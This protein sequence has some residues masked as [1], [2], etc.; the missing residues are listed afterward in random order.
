MRSRS[1]A[2]AAL[3]K[4]TTRICGTASPRSSSSRRY[5]PQRVQVLPVPAEASIR[6]VPCQRAGEDVEG[7]RRRVRHGAALLQCSST[8]RRRAAARCVE[9]GVAADR[10]RRATPVVGGVVAFGERPASLDCQALRAARAAACARSCPRGLGKK[11]SGSHRPRRYSATSCS[12]CAAASSTA[13][14]ANGA[15]VERQPVRAPAATPRRRRRTAPDGCSQAASGRR[16]APGRSASAPGRAGRRSAK[17]ACSARSRRRSPV[18]SV[19][20][21]AAAAARPWPRALRRRSRCSARS[22]RSQLHCAERAVGQLGAGAG[23]RT[24]AR[25]ASAPGSSSRQQ[26]LRP[27]AAR[28][29]PSGRKGSSSCS[30]SAR[31][32]QARC[33]GGGAA[34]RG[35]GCGR[36]RHQLRPATTWRHSALGR[37]QRAR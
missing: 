24:A 36:T 18:R 29:R 3:V 23:Q 10:P 27:G 15:V 4:V 35:R 9:V 13:R 26:P 5:R 17:P 22:S 1:S 8:G 33:P 25:R 30:S 14:G 34:G 20:G 11:C 2:V 16:R 32:G 37:R 31:R 19:P 7:T 6:C 28:L 12:S 21:A